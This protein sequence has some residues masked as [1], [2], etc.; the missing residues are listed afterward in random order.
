MNICSPAATTATSAMLAASTGSERP[1]SVTST[2]VRCNE[3]GPG[4]GLQA[5]Q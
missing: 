4:R 1:V 3:R 5:T 2:I